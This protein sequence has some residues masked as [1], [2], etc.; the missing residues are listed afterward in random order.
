MTRECIECHLPTS[1]DPCHHCGLEHHISDDE[2]EGMAAD[3]RIATQEDAYALS[4]NVERLVSEVKNLRA[5]LARLRSQVVPWLPGGARGAISWDVDI[6]DRILIQRNALP[7]GSKDTLFTQTISGC[8]M[9]E[10][11]PYILRYCPLSS[12]PVP[13][14]RDESR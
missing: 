8:S 12:I 10:L 14:Q 6:E 13:E 1:S 11:F 7:L 4:R 5:E 2:L 3:A 9:E